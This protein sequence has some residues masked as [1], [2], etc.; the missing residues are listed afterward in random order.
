MIK[1]IFAFPFIAILALLIVKPYFISGFPYTH[2]GENHLARFANYKVAIK[3]GQLPPRFAPNLMNH[4]GYPV[5]NYN[6]PLANIISLPFSFLNI[7]YEITFKV[8]SSLFIFSGLWGIYHWLNKLGASYGG[9][10]IGIATFAASPFIWSTVLFRGNIGEIMAWGIFP[11]LLSIIDSLRRD[12]EWTYKLKGF[13][14][15]LF[16]LSHN[17]AVVFG[18]P[19]LL[20]YA[21][22]REKGDRIFWARFASILGFGIAL[23]LWFWLPAIAEKNLVNVGDVD[24]VT[25]FQDHFPSLRQILIS[26]LSF[27]FSYPGKI[28]G[29]SFSLG[30]AQIA[31]LLFTLII[32]IK[33]FFSRTKTI[34]SHN[35]MLLLTIGVFALIFFQLPASL[36]IWKLIPILS[37]IQFTW[38]LNLFTSIFISGIAALSWTKM[39]K[40][41]KAIL[42]FLLIFQVSSFLR[43]KPVDYF[44]RTNIDYDAFSQSTTTNN[45]NLPK[46]FTYKEIWDWQ[47]T[48][49]II[50]GEGEI[51]IDYWTGSKRS[52]YLNGFT[53]VT[54]AEPT[55]SFAGWETVVSSN[56]NHNRVD[57]IN[58]DQIQGRIS[59]NIDE[60]GEYEIRTNFSQKTWPRMIGNLISIVGLLFA[61]TL[62]FKKTVG[63]DINFYLNW[64]ILLF[65]I[66]I[67]AP[68][69]LTYDPSFPYANS[70]LANS[71]LPDFIYSWANFDGVHYLTIIEKGYKETGLIQA[72]FPLFPLFIKKLE[73]LSID[74]ILIGLLL[75][76]ILGFLLLK[77]WKKISNLELR[78]KDNNLGVHVLFLFPTAFFFAA[79]YSEALFLLLVLVSFLSARKGRWLKAGLFAALASA[80]RLV[81]IFLIPALLVELWIQK[82]AQEKAND[83]PSCCLWRQ[84]IK[85][86]KK[87]IFFISLGGVGLLSYMFYLNKNFNDPLY[88][89]HV[90]SEFGG[91]RQESLIL[92]PQVVW[93]Y[94]KILWTARPFDL[95]YF[96]Y[97]QE[98][99]F[100]TLGLIGIIFSW[101]RVRKS[102]VVFSA[103]VFLLPTL[104]GTFSSMPRYFLVS[105][106]VLLLITKILKDR[107]IAKYLW[108][109]LST[110]LLIFNTILFIQGYW[111]A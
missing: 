33:S 94:I 13:T 39:G 26:P 74:P 60:P 10:L 83:S 5:F 27:G 102:Y 77:V 49:Q 61:L 1:K 50:Q 2:D 84:F 67:S 14:M 42:I 96:A 82:M 98:F 105:F 88:F 78:F 15:A 55:M 53:P 52:Y 58:N 38:R 100:G 37:F 85:T 106:S 75:N 101:F 47:P 64:K 71:G 35:S 111:V 107:P 70:I 36:F 109:G 81:G 40:E 92:Y 59:Y 51:R 89:Y 46:E 43:L 18:I 86:Y 34:I 31:T 29:I 69:L 63:A 41:L 54:I 108:L 9:I 103:L 87:E 90:Q 65:F 44:H 56:G 32:L 99:I 21:F 104:T 23:S 19:I 3:E 93:R 57:Y 11:W 28:D 80:T 22:L 72:F 73:F 6:Y 95:K 16:M 48:P 62:I 110:L 4:Y 24:L 12:E 97:L 8:I 76:F 66:T 7:N 20:I 79:M 25:S 68:L 17:I 30:L 45:E 91:G